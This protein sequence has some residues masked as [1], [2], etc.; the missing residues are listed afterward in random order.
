MSNKL[1]LIVEGNARIRPFT[2]TCEPENVDVFMKEVKKNHI[3]EQ[4]LLKAIESKNCSAVESL[5][6]RYDA[7][8]KKGIFKQYL[9]GY[10]QTIIA[11]MLIF[12]ASCDTAIAMIFLAY[13]AN[14]T[15]TYTGY[16][17]QVFSAIKE[18]YKRNDFALVNMLLEDGASYMDIYDEN[19]PREIVRNLLTKYGA[20]Y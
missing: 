12:A 11:S 5:M 20:V 1:C 2:I 8:S 9:T 17:G 6:I 18:A 16:D 13:E 3:F 7:E 10:Y 19:E 15:Y 4:V 14:A